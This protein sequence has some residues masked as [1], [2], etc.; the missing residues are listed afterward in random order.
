MAPHRTSHL[1]NRLIAIGFSVIVGASLML[2]KFYIYWITNSSA[3]LSDA[4]E[5]IINVVAS[6]FALVSILLSAKP[7]DPTHPYGHGKIEYFSAGFEGALIAFAAFGILWTA[8][9]QI[10]TPHPLPRL[11]SGILM[12]IGASTV[13]LILGMGLLSVG[14]KTR[15]IVLIADGRH[16]LTD[17][18]TSAGVV[19]GLFLVHLTGWYWLDGAIAILVA[20]NILVIGGRLMRESFSGLM[21]ASD[22]ELLQRICDVLS[23]HRKDSWIDV[24]RLRALRSGNRIHLDLHLILPRDLTLEEAHREASEMQNILFAHVEGLTDALIHAEPCIDPECPI[25]SYDP[26]GLRQKP[27]QRQSR[28][29]R[30][31]LTYGAQEGRRPRDD[32]AAGRHGST[33]EGG[34]Q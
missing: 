9:P 21:D 8:I 14:R 15:S 16:I 23:E 30:D 6:G 31:M 7:P 28:W 12:L 1:R 26:C 10:L 24:H 29:H 34:Y 2:A 19:A 13:N 25:C 22:P 33:E 17:V 3:I 20:I 5:S 18:Y 4:L 11:E 27:K 32:E